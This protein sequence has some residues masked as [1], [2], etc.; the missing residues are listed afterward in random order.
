MPVESCDRLIV[1]TSLTKFQANLDIA[2]GDRVDF[3]QFFAY[4]FDRTIFLQPTLQQL[5]DE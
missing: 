5:D 2:V 4:L 1:L 3:G